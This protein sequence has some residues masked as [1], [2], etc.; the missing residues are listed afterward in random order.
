M[1]EG[2]KD[3]YKEERREGFSTSV[4]VW[5]LKGVD[6][7]FAVLEQVWRK[8]IHRTITPMLNMKSLS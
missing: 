8:K 5:S 4:V 7:N 2:N 1:Q 6:G 3:R